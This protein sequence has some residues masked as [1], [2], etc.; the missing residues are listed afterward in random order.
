M[1]DLNLLKSPFFIIKN[2]QQNL[3]RQY[4][5]RLTGKVLDIG[6][7]R[8]PYRNFLA[9]KEYVGIDPDPN[10]EPDVVANVPGLPFENE[11]FDGVLCTEVLEHTAEP[12]E[13]LKDIRRVLKSGGL[14]YLSAPMSW[15]LHYEP[16]DFFR[17]TKFGLKYLLE[18]TGFEILEIERIGGFASLCAQRKIDVFYFLLLRLKVPEKL[19]LV[20]LAPFS[21]LSYLLSLFFDKIDERDALGWMVLATKK[22]P[23][24]SH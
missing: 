20:L 6:C 5:P 17:Y 2:L 18:K 24:S 12:K 9:A 3:V 15:C 14:L 13:A 10:V 22:Y 8:R 23:H 4:G 21:V 11:S 7:G 19:A 1:F 16:K